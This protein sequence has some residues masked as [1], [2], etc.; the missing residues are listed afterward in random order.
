MTSITLTDDPVKYFIKQEVNDSESEVYSV[1][2][3]P[4]DGPEAKEALYKTTAKYRQRE[5]LFNLGHQHDTTQEYRLTLWA[6]MYHPNIEI[7]IRLISQSWNAR[8]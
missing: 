5:H 4:F 7:K 2:F 1:E 6:V 3:D 8:D